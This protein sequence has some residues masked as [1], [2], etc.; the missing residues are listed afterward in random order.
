MVCPACKICQD[1]GDEERVGVANQCLAGLKAHT[2]RRNPD[3]TL[4][5]QRLESPETWV[6]PNTTGQKEKQYNNP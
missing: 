1:N 3:L 2:M 5:V 4:S 6:K